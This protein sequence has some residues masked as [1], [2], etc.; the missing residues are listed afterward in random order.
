MPSTNAELLKRYREKRSADS[1]PEPFGAQVPSGGQLFVVHKHAA[2]NL[3]WDLRLEMEGV[4]RSWAV[5]KGPSP[6]PQDKR[7]AVRVEDHPLEYGNFEGVIP[8]GNYGAGGTIVWDRGT[9]NPVE[10]PV[11]GLDK[12]KL[13]F[14]LQGYKLRGRWTLV[15]LRKSESE[16][17]L[18]KERDGLASEES[19]EHFPDDSVLSGLTLE[20]LESG[21]NVERKLVTKMKRAGAKPAH[22]KPKE[23][24]PMLAVAGEVF[25][26]K[27][28]V[29]ELKFDGY[30]L[31]AI[32]ENDHVYLQSRN[33]HDLT[34]SFPEIRQTIAM[35][36]YA[37]LVIDGEV[38]VHD[39]TGRPSFG[40]LQQRAKLNREHAVQIASVH[41]PA[42]LYAF[43]L[44]GAAGYDL[45]SLA[46]LKRKAFLEEILPS[47]GPIRYSEHIDQN[48][49]GL[50]QMAQEMHLEGIVGK[51]A[52]GKYKSARS[53]DW[54]KVRADRTGDY[55]VIGFTPSRSNAEDIG[56]LL[57]GEYR[58]G[59]LVYVGRVGSGLSSQIREELRELFGQS[60]SADPFTETGP[61]NAR[62]CEPSLVAEVRYKEY[63]LDG[64]LRQPVFLRL[65]TDKTPEECVS[66]QT[67]EPTPIEIEPEEH[68]EVLITNREKVFW[69]Q[70][71]YTKGDLVDYYRDIA[72]WILP[73]LKDRP[74]VLTRFPDGWE[75]KSFYQR[76]A[77]AF[78]P[79]WIRIEVL[80]SE[81]TE[82][83]VRYFIINDE[84][85]LAYLANMATLPIH[86]WS[87]RLGSLERPDWCI[88]DLDPK[89]APFRDVIDAALTIHAL[90]DEIDLPNFVKT[91]GSSGLHVLIPLG[92]QLTH[93]QCRTLGEL[94]A[95]V[96]VNTLPDTTTIARVV[97]R[98]EGK[99]YI[100]F[101]QNGHGRVLVS[102]FCVRAV[103]TASVSMPLS[104][105]EVN[106]RLKNERFHIK[107]AVRRMK[108]LKADPMIDVLET[109]P[110]LESALG[111]LAAKLA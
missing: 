88:L 100:D 40:L 108:R 22:F 42:T 33:G 77:P 23:L 90:C 9:W 34:A 27:G 47:V 52:D 50:Y 61:K 16:W 29:F 6:N 70:K 8:E 32:K 89:D 11:V 17:L 82:R 78:V 105:D 102:P 36:P 55:A 99:V 1:T 51:R 85:S 71:G 87:S 56:A 2:R 54:V 53:S 37:Q 18:I 75:G 41:R 3:H 57:V 59:E 83:D 38:V 107:N 15:R 46:L 31:L 101:M 86:L 62:W 30:R 20:Q 64:H 94:I 109:V 44:L 76:D 104:W 96:T 14:D 48:G 92:R 24:R 10:D 81:S 26:R 49:H 97:E 84:A 25:S 63:T 91:S 35:L 21:E 19:T 80:Y 60:K 74:I 13:L 93:D 65:R 79:D 7:L 67:L 68:H 5:P 39:D 95:R 98:R 28:W 69:P 12:G 73:Y 111:R 43:D 110:D 66:Q 103:E 45:R 4:L 72:P 106:G 58:E